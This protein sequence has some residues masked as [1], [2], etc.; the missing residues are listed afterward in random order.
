MNRAFRALLKASRHS[1][2]VALMVGGGLTAI[3]TQAGAIGLGQSSTISFLGQ[4]LNLVVP[5]REDADEPLTSEC[6]SAKVQAGDA[7]IPAPL[8]HVS[9]DASKD[10][11]ARILR[12]T[13]EPRIVEPVVTIDISVGCPVRLMRRFVIFV[14]P[15][16]L[17]RL[18]QVESQRSG[19]SSPV[20]VESSPR[21][22]DAAPNDAPGATAATTSPGMAAAPE[23]AR[24]PTPK[25]TQTTPDTARYKRAAQRTA[26][27]SPL[28]DA[29]RADSRATAK[30]KKGTSKSDRQ[31]RALAS[32]ATEGRLQLQAVKITPLKSATETASNASLGAISAAPVQAASAAQLVEPVASAASVPSAPPPDLILAAEPRIEAK[33]GESGMPTL[34]TMWRAAREGSVWPLIFGFIGLLM[35]VGVVYIWRL[36]SIEARRRM[37]EIGRPSLLPAVDQAPVASSASAATGQKMVKHVEVDK[38]AATES[39]ARKEGLPKDDSARAPSSGLHGHEHAQAF[40]STGTWA[41]FTSAQFAEDSQSPDSS[42]DSKLTVPATFQEDPSQALHSSFPSLPASGPASFPNLPPLG[43]DVSVE[44]LIDLEQQAEFCVALGQDQEAIDLLASHVQATGGSSALPFLKLLEIYKR[45]GDQSS[46]NEWRGRFSQRF[47]VVPPG[48]DGELSQGAGLE[49][50]TSVMERIQVSWHDFGATMALLQR[51]LVPPHDDQTGLYMVA[52]SLSLP[53]YQDLLLLY[54][55]ARDLSE[56][57]VQGNEVDVFLPLDQPGSSPVSTSMMA[58][59]PKPVEAHPGGLA[60]LD[61]D[62]NLGDDKP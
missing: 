58:T 62:I 60:D 33:R 38:G 19:Q 16:V 11:A 53:A 6:V 21:Q 49:A 1:S 40:V 56:H 10:G 23:R 8:I 26:E 5:V 20:G 4:A 32:S 28:I 47:G 46:Y 51:L 61:L 29:D 34:R 48:W 39:E 36:P 12:V 17:P 15:P 55:V 35:M 45:L 52:S 7:Q 9:L 50:Y 41:D 42:L 37:A 22:Q 3:V 18:A 25:A 2:L 27:V 30:P 14:D 31:T 57:E 59:L 24:T 54:S 44:K 13:T 43:R